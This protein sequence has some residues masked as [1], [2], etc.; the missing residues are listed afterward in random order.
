MLGS[1]SKK[2]KTNK[3]TNKNRKRQ[4]GTAE[5]SG[6]FYRVSKQ[7]ETEEAYADQFLM[8]RKYPDKQRETG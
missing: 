8:S 1:L 6:G 2:Q 4:Q 7:R 5:T 3:Q